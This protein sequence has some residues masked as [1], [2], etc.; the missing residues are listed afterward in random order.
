[1]TF[2]RRC[3]LHIRTCPFPEFNLWDIHL[4]EGLAGNVNFTWCCY[5]LSWNCGILLLSE[6][7]TQLCKATG[8]LWHSHLSHWH[9]VVLGFE[10]RA[11]SWQCS[12]ST[13]WGTPPAQFYKF[14]QYICIAAFK[15]QISPKM[16]FYSFCSFSA[17]LTEH[18]VIKISISY[19]LSVFNF[20]CESKNHGFPTQQRSLNVMMFKFC[21]R[22]T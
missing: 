8:S 2:P 4:A 14:G 5:V 16:C 1:M 18:W 15:I 20:F 7:G 9:L 10:L 11:L 6:K 19:R 17:L 12:Y 21:F 22:R 3:G 13:I